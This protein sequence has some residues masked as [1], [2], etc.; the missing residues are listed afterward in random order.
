M[1]PGVYKKYVRWKGEQNIIYLRML[2][3]PYWMLVSLILY[4][5]CFRKDIE[6]IVF[7]VNP[8]GIF[9]NNQMKCG[10]QQTVTWHVDDFKSRHVHPKIND[11]FT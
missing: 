8:Y 2:K 5:K 10:K 11:E 3:A 6:E 4:H 7:K 9:V 1:F